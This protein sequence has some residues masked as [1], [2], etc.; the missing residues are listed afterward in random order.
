MRRVDCRRNELYWREMMSSLS[1]ITSGG[2][3]RI[4]C[5]MLFFLISVPLCGQPTLPDRVD[6]VDIL[7]KIGTFLAEDSLQEVVF[8]RLTE[9]ERSQLA[10]SM[11]SVG[12]AYDSL[13]KELGFQTLRRFGDM[14][15][16]E[17]VG[18]LA[19]S[20]I[21]AAYGVEEY[22][23]FKRQLCARYNEYDCEYDFDEEMLQQAFQIA[24]EIVARR[25]GYPPDIYAAFTATGEMITLFGVDDLAY[26]QRISV[27]QGIV[28][29]REIPDPV[30]RF[31]APEE[32]IFWYTGTG[33]RYPVVLQTD[34]GGA[35]S[36]NVGRVE[37]E[38][39][40]QYLV[41][42]SPSEGEHEIVI[43]ASNS[44][45]RMAQ[46]AKRLIV[47]RPELYGEPRRQ[48]FAVAR[49][50][51]YYQPTTEWMSTRI[52]EEHYRTVVSFGER[53]VFMREGT[54]FPISILPK[55]LIV[56]AT[57][58]PIK[59]TVYWLPG[60]DKSHPVP[61]MSTD[62]AVLPVIAEYRFA[63][64]VP[65]YIP[66]VYDGSWSFEF[67]ITQSRRDVEFDGI[68]ATQKV[69]SEGQAGI[70]SIVASCTECP[71]WGIS[72][73][74]VTQIDDTTWKLYIEVVDWKHVLEKE[75]EL[76][77]RRFAI[78]LVLEG[79]GSV[80]GVASIGMTV[81]LDDLGEK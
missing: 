66:P 31:L 77:G 42:S 54:R 39:W 28:A 79:R 21:S 6:R 62:P 51:S 80:P 33:F 19:E 3:V 76:D 81:W 5:L 64:I 25:N 37:G 24:R 10:A 18:G 65:E 63:P 43:A 23:D 35:Y 68:I 53:E 58:G 12:W 15:G 69:G 73:P 74:R 70:E 75:E 8:F 7:E 45:G 1:D 52:P 13:E 32:K 59:T 36:F 48:P 29:A 57:S 46:D 14:I 72:Q 40:N 67:P 78:D 16:P 4:L 26:G 2:S 22:A 17:P 50:G 44:S 49:V 71:D 34:R 9:E 30:A 55:E 27:G 47:A 56:E 20:A 61:L 60:G 11:P 41:W 38:P